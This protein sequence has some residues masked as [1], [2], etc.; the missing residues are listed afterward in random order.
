M[1]LRRTDRARRGVSG[2]PSRMKSA[3]RTSTAS[4]AARRVRLAQGRPVEVVDSWV[5][6][7]PQLGRRRACGLS[8]AGEVRA[9]VDVRVVDDLAPAA[10]PPGW[11][12]T[13]REVPRRPSSVGHPRGAR[14][15]LRDPARAA[16]SGELLQRPSLV[17]EAAPRGSK[18]GGRRPPPRGYPRM[19]GV[20]RRI[21]AS[22]EHAALPPLILLSHLKRREVTVAAVGQDANDAAARRWASAAQHAARPATAAPPSAR[23]TAL[24]RRPAT[25]GRVPRLLG[26][27]V[28]DLVDALV[29]PPDAPARWTTGMCLSP[30]RPCS[31]SVGLDGDDAGSARSCSFEPPAGAHDRAGGADAGDEVGEP[32]AERRSRISAPVP[33]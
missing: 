2:S 9:H 25:S 10:S 16:R 29:R 22:A 33:R 32:I 12:S 6:R 31:A 28:H 26:V 27:H 18:A 7:R 15:R 21:A 19:L 14:A 24:S 13:E 8:S 11:R 20:T 23:R 3:V 17:G 30:S 1:P 5:D 4:T